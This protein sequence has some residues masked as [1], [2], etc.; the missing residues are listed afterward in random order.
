M[1]SAQLA[2]AASI[3][4]DGGIAQEMTMTAAPH[5]TPRC[6]DDAP[7]RVVAWAGETQ[8]QGFQGWYGD[9]FITGVPVAM[10]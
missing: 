6:L 4:H 2:E 9:W 10:S 1:A 8:V 3:R 7:R 5:P